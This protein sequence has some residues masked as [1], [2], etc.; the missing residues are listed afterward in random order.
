MQQQW[1]TPL[2]H[3][4]ACFTAL[5]GHG[6]GWTAVTLHGAGA[7][8]SPVL[9]WVAWLG[10]WGEGTVS[11]LITPRHLNTERGLPADPGISHHVPS[12]LYLSIILCSP[13][14]SWAPNLSDPSARHV[15][16]ALAYVAEGTRERGK[17]W[18]ERA[19]AGWQNILSVLLQEW[20]DYAESYSLA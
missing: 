15:C 14:S 4:R 9:V 17:N 5:W 7:A 16:P 1:L 3:L 2:A 19:T 10:V 20:R 12:L 13:N 8:G 6:A 11:L 18:G